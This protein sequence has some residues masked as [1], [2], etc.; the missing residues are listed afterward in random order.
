MYAL[1]NDSSNKLYKSIN[2]GTNF[3]LITTLY[4]EHRRAIV[5][6]GTTLYI[7]GALN[8]DIIKST[9][10][11]SNWVKVGTSYISQKSMLISKTSERFFSSSDGTSFHINTP[12][13]NNTLLNVSGG[14]IPISSQNCCGNS[15]LTRVYVG[16]NTGKVHTVTITWGPTNATTSISCDVGVILNTSDTGY[17]KGLACSSNGTIVYACTATGKIYKSTNSGTSF[18]VLSNSSTTSTGNTWNTMACSLDGNT[19]VAA[20]SGGLIY[21][22]TNGGETWTTGNSISGTWW[23]IDIFGTKLVAGGGGATRKYWVGNIL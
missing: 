3:T 22:S 8:R 9:D 4:T 2:G 17:I 13:T 18:N 21:L 7:G 20:R 11:G 10:S 19:V 12:H 5:A 23:W 16:S 15:D 6:N 14:N 1:Y